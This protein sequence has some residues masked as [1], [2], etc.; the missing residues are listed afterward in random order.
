MGCCLV[1]LYVVCVVVD[2]CGI[3]VDLCGIL[4]D[5]FVSIE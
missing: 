4:V 2:L 3:V 1:E 5:I